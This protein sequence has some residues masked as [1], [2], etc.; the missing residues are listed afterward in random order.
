V[1]PAA[2]V[3][4]GI[5]FTKAPAWV[6]S[7]R[8]TD[9]AEPLSEPD[10]SPTRTT[11]TSELS[12]AA[13]GAGAETATAV[14]DANARNATAAGSRRGMRRPSR[15]W[16]SDFRATLVGVRERKLTKG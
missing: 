5:V 14:N 11:T 10:P 8:N 4:I 1:T 6:Y 12:A 13:T 7:S 15:W 3:G 2:S 9:A 16:S